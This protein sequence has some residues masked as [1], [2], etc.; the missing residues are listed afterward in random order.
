ML[1]AMFPATV[2]AAENAAPEVVSQQ[3]NLG[4]DLTL[5]FYVKADSATVVNVTVNG[6]PVA[7]DLGAM[8]A[9]S[10]GYYVIPARLA[11]AQMT[12]EITLDFLQNDV[13]VLQKTYTIRDYAVAILEGNYPATTKKLVR[14]MLSYGGS[15]QQY[16]GV[17]TDNLAD[18]GYESTDAVTLPSGYEAMS[19]NGSISGLQ[20]YGASLVFDSK[21]AVRYYFTGS[22]ENIDFGD[23][24]VVAKGDMH[25]VEVPGI[26]PQDYGKCVVLTAA[27][28]G[29]SLSM[30]YSPLNYIVR[31]S[32]KGSETLK[33]L[34]SALYG[35]H[36]AAVE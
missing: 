21:I 18:A 30:S 3:L 23:Y 32:Q 36:A 29:E 28:G 33:P 5:K 24:D 25:Y 15:A 22:V 2:M 13:S 27:K 1:L 35:Y 7:Y 26:N 4:D 16:F 6:N 20:F 8:Q 12:E 17:N 14:N 11:A 34:L 9:N 10:D 19:V 31:M